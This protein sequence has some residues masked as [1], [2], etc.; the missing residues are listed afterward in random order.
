[1]MAVGPLK[2]AARTALAARGEH[3]NTSAV[4]QTLSRESCLLCQMPRSGSG[5][6]GLWW[7]CPLLVASTT[8]RSFFIGSP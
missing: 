1:M 6:E 7:R 3:D 2:K 5:S 8:I 4:V